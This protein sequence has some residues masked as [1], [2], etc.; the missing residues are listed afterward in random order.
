M[1]GVRWLFAVDFEIM[2]GIRVKKGG[3]GGGGHMILKFHGIF[4]GNRR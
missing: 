3:R 1:V 4:S 2:P